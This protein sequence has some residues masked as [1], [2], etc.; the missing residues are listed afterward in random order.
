MA[1]ARVRNQ[2]L[3][4]RSTCSD[5]WAP[6]EAEKRTRRTRRRRGAATLEQ[7]ASVCPR[8]LRNAQVKQ[9]AVSIM[10]TARGT[11]TKSSRHKRK[12]DTN[13][14]PHHVVAQRWAPSER[15]LCSHSFVVDCGRPSVVAIL[16][17]PMPEPAIFS[18]SKSSCA[19]FSL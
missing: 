12:Q 13:Q 6:R 10:D 15:S 17:M 1:T 14:P 7:L 18:M 8:N 5:G 16:L 4:N 3:P 19:P 9:L 11:K 2:R